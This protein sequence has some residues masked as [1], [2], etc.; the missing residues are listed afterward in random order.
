[1]REP[2]EVAQHIDDPHIAETTS[3]A[4]A[5]RDRNG[6]ILFGGIRY[7]AST[8]GANRWRPPEHRERSTELIDATR[9]GP[10][11]PQLPGAGMTNSVAVDWSEDCL[12]L[13]VVTP[14]LDDG[15]RPVY[16]WIHGGAY[17]HGQG[18]TPW[19]DGTSF[20]VQGDIVTV[21]IN[22][23]LGIF[24]YT[25]FA[26]FDGGH[27]HSGHVGI[28]DQL[29]ALRWVRDNIAA[30]G[31]DPG[32]VTLGGESAGAFS[33]GNLLGHPDSAG[34][35]SRAILQ[36]GA[37]HN[38]ISPDASGQ[39]AHQVLAEAEVDSVDALRG[40]SA[41]QLL[42][43]Q[44]KVI[45]TF[46]RPPQRNPLGLTSAAFYP[47]FYDEFY[48]SQTLLEAAAVRSAG[49]PVLMGTNRDELGL[50]GIGGDIDDDRLER[51]V[52]GLTSE[53]DDVVAVYRDEHSGAHN[54]EIARRLGTDWT[55][56]SPAIAL[57]EARGNSPTFMYH[58]AWASRAFDGA[59][60]ACHALE[61]PFTFNTLASGGAEVF[62]GPGDP[63][64]AV[65]DSMHTCWINFIR[66]GDP[67]NDATPGWEPYS[68]G[69]RNVMEFAAQCSVLDDPLPETRE[70]WS[71]RR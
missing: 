31:G 54:G 49:I 3:G 37:A 70:F 60:G 22:Y 47:T 4:V 12:S 56:R 1:V 69:N 29:A 38:S 27:E 24:G 68:P 67:R 2:L 30:F 50:W 20:A 64:T 45:A 7:A 39:I 34:L 8:A 52:S 44:E 41:D 63:P 23:R 13:N 53:I 48:E 17:V 9:F 40:V 61:I 43:I 62:L 58:F 18:A 35:F 46:G 11:A 26:N 42:E 19:Y 71:T 55:F 57:A 14:A 65:A 28:L 5:G 51:Y 59:L 15:A 25:N 16:V 21:T 32:R 33:V 10:A 36:S 6:A 66:D